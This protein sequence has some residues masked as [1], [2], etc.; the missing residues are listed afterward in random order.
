MIEEF[1]QL[2]LDQALATSRQR[3]VL[4]GVAV[5]AVVVA[6]VLAMA[7]RVPAQGATIMLTISVAA[8]I[9]AVSAS[10]THIGVIVVAI[11]ILQWVGYADAETSLR[12][13][14]VA[15]CLYLFHALTALIASTPHTADIAPVVLRRWAARSVLVT[16]ATIAVWGLVVA[17][18]QRSDAGSEVVTVVGLAVIA[19]VLVMVRRAYATWWVG[20]RR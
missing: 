4:G 2:R 16:A 10:G 7:G 19:G 17:F 18:E 13:V 1:L 8:A 11:V 3:W 9:V 5:L 6:S 15:L 20:P 12:T 14:G